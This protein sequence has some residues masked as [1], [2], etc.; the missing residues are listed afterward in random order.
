MQLFGGEIWGRRLGDTETPLV[1]AI[2]LSLAETLQFSRTCFKEEIIFLCLCEKGV[3]ETDDLNCLSL[4]RSGEG[5]EEVSGSSI[6]L[7]SLQP[8]PA[9]CLVTGSFT[10]SWVACPGWAVALPFP[11]CEPQADWETPAKI[12]LFC[13]TG[14]KGWWSLW[15]WRTLTMALVWEGAA[16][17][18]EGKLHVCPC[19]PP[20][21]R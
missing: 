5:Q 10:T 15:V 18:Q 4:K 21:I 3:R 19:G 8:S 9:V 14:E 1:W 2:A 13:I 20:D 16:D 11:W 12:C 6:T 17:G 7:G